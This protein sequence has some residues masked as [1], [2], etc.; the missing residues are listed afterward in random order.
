MDLQKKPDTKK[1]QIKKVQNKCKFLQELSRDTHNF[2]HLFGRKKD[3]IQ[4]HFDQFWDYH[5][6]IVMQLMQKNPRNDKSLAKIF[7]AGKIRA[8]RSTKKSTKNTQ[9]YKNLP[10][11]KSKTGEKTHLR[12]PCLTAVT[13]CLVCILNIKFNHNVLSTILSGEETT[14][15]INV[16]LHL[17]NRPFPWGH[18]IVI[19]MDVFQQSE[20]DNLQI[21]CCME[22]TPKA[23]AQKCDAHSPPWNHSEDFLSWAGVHQPEIPTTSC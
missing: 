19:P 16:T 8:K 7:V 6:C 13:A 4:P 9:K 3:E 14:D 1:A 22:T 10:K 21:I 12:P 5:G 17:L 2:F 18:A 20:D 23:I 15:T 11:S